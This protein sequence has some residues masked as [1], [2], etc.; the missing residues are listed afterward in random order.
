[1]LPF[2]LSDA[3]HMRLGYSCGSG[4]KVDQ[5][6]KVITPARTGH[7]P[8]IVP[9]FGSDILATDRVTAVS[10]MQ[11]LWRW[12]TELS[13]TGCHRL[14]VMSACFTNALLSWQNADLISSADQDHSFC[15]QSS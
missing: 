15:T 4:P 6:Q 7:T 2:A 11:G 14:E 8:S 10:V 1:M 5:H 13:C 3:L 12:V 9:Y